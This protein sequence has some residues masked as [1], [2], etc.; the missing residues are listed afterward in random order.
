VRTKPRK[1]T[2]GI[3]V[4]I[5]H[6]LDEDDS[7][8]TVSHLDEFRQRVES[9]PVETRPVIVDVDME[10]HDEDDNVQTPEPTA[11]NKHVTFQEEEYISVMSPGEADDYG[12]AEA[13]VDV[14]EDDGRLPLSEKEANM[15]KK[16]NDMEIKEALYDM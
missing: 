16:M 9:R 3:A 13:D 10:K 7:F 8:G 12:V 6:N 1:K 2:K 14:I 5:F 15:Q 11:E 4:P